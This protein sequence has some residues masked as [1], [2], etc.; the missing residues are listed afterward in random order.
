MKDKNVDLGDYIHKL[1]MELV[2]EGQL[3]QS[4]L[5]L[6]DINLIEKVFKKVLS[7]VYH[8]RIEYPEDVE[9]GKRSGKGD[10]VRPERANGGVQSGRPLQDKPAP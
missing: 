1:I 9:N 2:E 8:N 10:R 6:K 3:N 4:G 5:S 7:G